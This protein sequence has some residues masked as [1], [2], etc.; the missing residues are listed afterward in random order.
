MIYMTRSFEANILLT[1]SYILR[2]ITS[3]S[4]ILLATVLLRKIADCC[5]N[6]VRAAKANPSSAVLHL[7]EK[8][9]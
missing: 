6:V 4:L 5:G 9:A 2:G 1:R 7:S 3:E 8:P